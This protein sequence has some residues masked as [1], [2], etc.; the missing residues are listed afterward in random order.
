MLDVGL[1]RTK[2]LEQTLHVVH[3]RP[4]AWTT[5]FTAIADALKPLTANESLPLVPFSEWF[6]KLEA[7]SPHE[8]ARVPALKLLGFF[9]GM[10]AGDDEMRAQGAIS[11]SR[12]ALG[13]AQLETI[14][15]QRASRTMATVESLDAK[16]AHRWVGYWRAQGLLI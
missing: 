1:D 3:P 7:T 8:V 15:V 16:D 14:K 11:D 5:I 4:V 2:P 13:A 10:A 6:A 12:E 9:H